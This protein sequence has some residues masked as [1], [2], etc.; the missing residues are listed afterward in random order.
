V[1][2]A[3]SRVLDSGARFRIIL[4]VR[5]KELGVRRPW[6]LTGPLLTATCS[7]LTS[8]GPIAQ[9]VEHCADN[10]G[11]GSSNLPGPILP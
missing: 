9:V 6:A 1:A 5:R 2:R 10:A 11:V 7:L 8:V 3:S 4:A